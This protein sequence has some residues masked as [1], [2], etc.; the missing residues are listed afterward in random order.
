MRL[1]YL[2]SASKNDSDAFYKLG[3]LSDN[4][5]GLQWFWLAAQQ[6]HVG[7]MLALAELLIKDSDSDENKTQAAAW[8]MMAANLSDSEDADKLLEEILKDMAESEK[9]DASILFT[10]M[11]YAD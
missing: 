9:L 4:S 11:F 7:S 1:I 5:E 8:A 2:F 3:L 10:E 6:K